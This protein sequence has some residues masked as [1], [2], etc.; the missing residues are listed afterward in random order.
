MAIVDSD[1]LNTDVFPVGESAQIKFGLQPADSDNTDAN[2]FIQLVSED[3]AQTTKWFARSSGTNGAALSG[4][5]GTFT[6]PTGARQYN[7]GGSVLLTARNFKAA[8]E[9]YSAGFNGTLSQPQENAGPVLGANNTQDITR[10]LFTG[11]A[12]NE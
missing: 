12:P 10:L 4:S 6:W 7:I 8:V 9:S 3:G 11:S 5:N 2:N 1:A